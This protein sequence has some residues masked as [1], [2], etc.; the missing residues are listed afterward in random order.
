VHTIAKPI[1]LSFGAVTACIDSSIAY[2]LMSGRS[3]GE[4]AVTDWASF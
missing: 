2:L 4:K 3:P 1:H